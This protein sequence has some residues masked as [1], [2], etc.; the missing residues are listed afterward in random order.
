MAGMGRRMPVIVLCVLAIAWGSVLVDPGPNQNAH[1]ARVTALSTGTPR[2]DAFHNWT[3]DTAYYKGHYY[4]A[5]A[6]GLA[7]VTLPWYFVLRET[8]LLVHGPPLSV[9]W[10]AAETLKMPHWAPWELALWGAL[11]PFLGIVL[12]VRSVAERLSPG[13]GSVTA[14]TLGAGSLVAVFATMFFDHELS[15]LLGFLAFVLLFRER[16]RAPQTQPLIAAGIVAG[17]AITVEFP[18][19]L[20]AAV[21]A[22]YAAARGDRLRRFAAFSGGVLLGVTPLLAYDYWAYGTF[23]PI[24]YAYAVLEPGRSGHDVLGANAS[25]FFGVDVPRPASLTS[26]LLDPKGL[27]ILTPVWALAAVG[28]VLLWR[29]GNRAE[30]ATAGAVCAVF[31]LYDAGYYLPFGGFNSGP[32]FLVPMLPF[33]ALGVGPA[34][35]ALPGPTL[36]LA[37]A[38]VVVTTVSILAN[39]MLVSEDVG[40]MFHRLERGGDVNGPIS[41]T[42]FHSLWKGVGP[43]L[44]VGAVVAGLVA[45]TYAPLARKLTR[46]D[47]AYGAAALLAWRAA[48]VGGAILARAPDGW[49]ASATLAAALA[50]ALALLFRGRWRSALPGLLLGMFLVPQIAGHTRI[51]LVAVSLILLVLVAVAAVARPQGAATTATP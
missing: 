23:K 15:A 43:L 24:A 37:C 50:L 21:L 31:L 51:A 26:L 5:K 27:L 10:P 18:L 30:A 4:A 7:V 8:G 14:V 39:P 22:F 20:T 41:W 6:P 46:R 17:L 49:V 38:S 11:L 40:T 1:M 47:L 19:A 45:L 34:W 32:R 13:Y 9:P 2:I 3:R 48:Y 42:V 29:Q 35:R 16:M 25:G 33:L 36:A 28:L 12:L 44:L